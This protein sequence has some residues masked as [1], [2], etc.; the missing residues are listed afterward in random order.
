MTGYSFGP[1][2][3]TVNPDQRDV[4]PNRQV[5]QFRRL[6]VSGRAGQDDA[7]VD[8]SHELVV[9]ERL[10]DLLSRFNMKA[11]DVDAWAG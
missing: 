8:A 1:M 7:G 3:T 9:S 4:N 5:P 6:I 11:C 2:R 10:W